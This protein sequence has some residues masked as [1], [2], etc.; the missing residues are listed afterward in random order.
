MLASSPITN[1]FCLFYPRLIFS[2]QQMHETVPSIQHGR[3]IH[4][5]PAR[6]TAAFNSP[7]MQ[8]APLQPIDMG[9]RSYSQMQNQS[10]HGRSRSESAP[11]EYLGGAV[12]DPKVRKL[13]ENNPIQQQMI[14]QQQQHESAA[15]SKRDAGGQDTYIESTAS[16]VSQSSDY[17]QESLAMERS[18][19]RSSQGSHHSREGF[20]THPRAPPVEASAGGHGK[21]MGQKMRENNEKSPTRTQT[22]RQVTSPKVKKKMPKMG[23]RAA[24]RQHQTQ[25]SAPPVQGGMPPLQGVPPAGYPAPPSNTSS[26]S[27]LVHSH[28]GEQFNQFYPGSHHP[29]NIVVQQPGDQNHHLRIRQ[30]EHPPLVQS[31][32]Y[33]G[34][35]SQRTTTPDSLSSQESYQSTQP[36][37]VPYAVTNIAAAPPPPDMRASR[38]APH[39]HSDSQLSQSSQVSY[40]SQQS[41]SSQHSDSSTRPVTSD[42]HSHVS[43]SSDDVSF[44]S[45]L[46]NASLESGAG[47]GYVAANVHAIANASLSPEHEAS[48]GVLGAAVGQEVVRS[49]IYMNTDFIHQK[50]KEKE[51][52]QKL[53]EMDKRDAERSGSPTLPLHINRSQR[54]NSEQKTIS[55]GSQD[56][57]TV[58]ELSDN[59]P[60]SE[61]E[62]LLNHSF[63]TEGKS[64]YKSCLLKL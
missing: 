2:R 35:S 51:Q 33:H 16:N 20:G 19:S 21:P 38:H 47:M 26:G 8:R 64:H 63:D 39:K 52:L 43:Q 6:S 41:L 62:A 22:G 18:V 23:V 30:G 57:K 12:P 29:S 56:E 31:M 10:F 58:V 4:Q 49:T 7:R 42:S 40:N 3:S 24:I 15:L 37:L 32:S 59:E 36:M 9:Q 44:N 48:A 13:N 34:R 53:R 1:H 25:Q 17:S 28:S 60:A 50:E 5:L 55:N 11:M 46:R 45:D 54:L 14:T 27:G 61:I